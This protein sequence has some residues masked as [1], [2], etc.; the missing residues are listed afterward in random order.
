[1]FPFIDIHIDGAYS[2]FY[3]LRIGSAVHTFPREQSGH[4]E[5]N[6][7]QLISSTMWGRILSIDKEVDCI[8]TIVHV[9]ICSKVIAGKGVS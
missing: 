9:H 8:I 6:T 7:Q 1:M 5:M 2:P 3:K 4:P